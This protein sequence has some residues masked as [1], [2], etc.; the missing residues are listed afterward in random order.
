MLTFCN[1]SD[2]VK[3]V[4]RRAAMIRHLRTYFA[5]V[6]CAAVFVLALSAS[7]HAGQLAIRTQGV[8][9][10]KTP[11]TSELPIKRL[12][13][14]TELEVISRDHPGWYFVLYQGQP[15]FVH[16]RYIRFRQNPN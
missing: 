15:G 9:F 2:M 16:Q 3:I 8:N 14:G 1:Q 13:A 12:K 11:N 10:R 4:S 6:I 7:T 5:R